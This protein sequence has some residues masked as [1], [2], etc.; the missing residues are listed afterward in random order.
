MPAGSREPMSLVPMCSRTMF[1]LPSSAGAGDQRG[2]LADR[3]ARVPL[4]HAREGLPR[5]LGRSVCQRASERDL[6]VGCDDQLEQLRA[7]AAV[8][9]RFDAPGDRIAERQD[10]AETAVRRARSVRGRPAGAAR[11]AGAPP[12]ASGAGAALPP[13]P[14]S[15]AALPAGAAWRRPCRHPPPVPANTDPPIPPDGCPP[16][17]A[18]PP[19]EWPPVGSGIP[20]IPPVPPVVCAPPVAPPDRHRWRS[21]RQ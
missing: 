5:H 15:C 12:A 3:P 1:G 6:L 10:L 20:P 19:P 17:A 9:R 8:V 11:G 4:V 21:L 13:V 2:E 14:L 16:V 7:V 18:P